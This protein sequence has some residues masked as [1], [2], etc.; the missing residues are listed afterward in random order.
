M[1]EQGDNASRL[2]RLGFSLAAFATRGFFLLLLRHFDTESDT[3][4]IDVEAKNADVDEDM[5]V[6]MTVTVD[7]LELENAEQRYGQ[8]F[9]V[10]W[11]SI[12][13]PRGNNQG[14]GDSVGVKQQRSQVER[15]DR[16]L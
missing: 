11:R 5:D 12:I 4:P 14:G 6:T 13:R 9:G 7:E 10:H 15:Q 3:H 2:H 1:Q 16:N 8:V